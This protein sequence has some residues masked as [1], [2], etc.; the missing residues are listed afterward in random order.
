MITL[1]NSAWMTTR[2]RVL[3]TDDKCSPFLAETGRIWTKQTEKL[4][5]PANAL[6]VKISVEKEIFVDQWREV[7]NGTLEGQSQ[8]IRITGLTFTSSVE[9]CE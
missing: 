4:T 5:L 8:C 9:K 1:E 2:L 3:Y 6:H 7:Y